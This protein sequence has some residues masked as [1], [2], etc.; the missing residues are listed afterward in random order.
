[1]P[2]N[3]DI[4]SGP[5]LMTYGGADVGEVAAA[6]ILQ[7]SA[8][9][10]D[11]TTDLFGDAVVD[12]IFRGI[13]MFMVVVFKEWNDAV[14]DAIWPWDVGNTPGSSVSAGS[15]LVDKAKA[16]VLT[17][18]SSTPAATYGPTSVTASKAILSP[19]HSPQISLGTEERDVPAVFRLYPSFSGTN[20]E[21][22][23]HV[24][25]API[26]GALLPTP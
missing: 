14:V 17:A 11:V 19:G 2:C 4:P 3:L 7:Y 26:D 10:R 9:A 22:A 6:K 16:I 24:V 15:C 8:E 5:Y 18:V 12:G 25:M 1:M 21:I 13:N 20:K 23:Q